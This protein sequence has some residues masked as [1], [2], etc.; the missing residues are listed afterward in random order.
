MTA[1]SSPSLS[2]FSCGSWNRTNLMELMRLPCAPAQLPRQ[3]I[4]FAAR[5]GFEPVFP[6]TGNVIQPQKR[7]WHQ[8]PPDYFGTRASNSICPY[9]FL[10][11]EF[12]FNG[13]ETPSVRKSTTVFWK[14]CINP[15]SLRIIIF[16]VLM[17]LSSV[18]TWKKTACIPD[19][20]RTND[21]QLRRLMLYPAELRRQISECVFGQ[22][23][24]LSL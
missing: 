12:R 17:I 1:L 6:I 18:R 4:F 2:L 13:L 7:L 3:V 14:T 19:W 23:K 9:F 22:S 24:S 21:P 20:I 8:L 5:T 15:R 11:F 16:F 10:A